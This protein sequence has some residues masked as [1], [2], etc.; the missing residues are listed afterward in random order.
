MS[1]LQMAA[2]SWPLA[3]GL[4]VLLGRFSVTHKEFVMTIRAKV[5]RWFDRWAMTLYVII[6]ILA[7]GGIAQGVQNAAQNGRDLVTSCQNANE[8]RQAARALWGYIID[9][10][11]ARNPEPTKEQERT[12]DNFRDYVNAV[13]VAH[14]CD[15]LSRKY[16]LPDPPRVVEPKR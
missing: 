4:G 1:M 3:F 8:S 12:I 16:P 10:S 11:E 7:L 14:D 5:R 2:V 9:L 15:D 13:Y 6:A